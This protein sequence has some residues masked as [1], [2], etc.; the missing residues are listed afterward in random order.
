LLAPY[1]APSGA[2]PFAVVHSHRSR[3]GLRSFVPDGTGQNDKVEFLFRVIQH[4]CARQTPAQRIALGPQLVKAGAR[5]LTS[6][7]LS[8]DFTEAMTDSAFAAGHFANSA[9]PLNLSATSS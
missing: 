8:M 2:W 6:D 5:L 9:Q 1:V 7:R 3:G 4:V